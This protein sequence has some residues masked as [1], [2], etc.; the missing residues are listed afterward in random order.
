[1]PI[2]HRIIFLAGG[3]VALCLIGVCLLFSAHWLSIPESHSFDA[4]EAAVVERNVSILAVWLLICGT[5]GLTVAAVAWVKGPV[6]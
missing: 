4:A 5:I 1:M 2:R 6:E 3:G